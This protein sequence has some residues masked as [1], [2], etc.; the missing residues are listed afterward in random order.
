MQR[1]WYIK[2]V[3]FAKL[4]YKTLSWND[5]VTRHTIVSFAGSDD[6]VR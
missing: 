3:V 1:Y 2:P 4:I 6:C 5:S